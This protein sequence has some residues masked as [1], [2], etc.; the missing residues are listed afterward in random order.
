MLFVQQVN[1]LGDAQL[2]TS[3][4][5]IAL[6]LLVRRSDY[7]VHSERDLH[8]YARSVFSALNKYSDQVSQLLVPFDRVA[9][10]MLSIGGSRALARVSSLLDLSLQEGT[11]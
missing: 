2:D 4:T 3:E 1:D 10:Q 5:L 8:K 11:E 9:D 6:A 7:P